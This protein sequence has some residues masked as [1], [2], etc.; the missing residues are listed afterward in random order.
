[1][2]RRS[3]QTDSFAHENPIPVATRIGPLLTSG[4]IPAFDPGTR[5]MP[6][7]L[8]DQVAN[9]FIHIGNALAGA[10]G[11]W[12]HVAKITFF[13]NDP[14]ARG[15]INPSW[16][17][18]FPDADSRPSR[19]TQITAEGGRPRISCDFIAYIED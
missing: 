10:G 18:K 4:I 16:L 19:H 15:K 3:I 9:L 5:N 14:E 13:A 7:A 1:M 12:E 6:E 2:A 17:E 11:G 8:E